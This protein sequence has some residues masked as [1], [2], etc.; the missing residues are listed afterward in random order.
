MLKNPRCLYESSIDN[1]IAIDRDTIFGK[2]CEGYHGDT[3]TTTREAWL[4]EIE[5][6]Q[7]QLLLWKDSNGQI[8]FEYDIP[9]LGKRIDVVLLLKGI[10]FCLEFKVGESKI[11]ENDIDQVLDY[12][13]DLR[14]FHKFSES[15]VI[16]PI[17][18][19]TKYQ[20]HSSIIQK[21]VYNDKVLNPLVTGEGGIQELINKV[22][23]LY[24]D[25][26]DI[27][28]NW[29]ISPYAPT[30]TII[31]AARTLY[32]SHSVENITRHEAD[33]VMTD[34]TIAYILD[35][36]KRSKEN[37]EKSICFVTGVPGAGKTLVGLDVAVKQTYRGTDAPVLDEGAIY[38]SGNG[39]LVA[40]LNEALALDNYTK[41]KAKGEK[42]NK[43]DSK[44]EVSKFIQIIHRYR[45]TMLAKIKNPVENGILEIDE[46]KAVKMQD[47]GYGEVEHVAI[48]DEAQR[49][50]THER[51][52]NYL[53]RG[54]TYGNKLKVPNFPMSEASFLI[55]SLDQRED[56]A[57]IVCLVGGGQE[58][59]TGEAGISEWIKS[60]NETFT[61]WKV[62]ISPKLTEA[63]YAEGQVNELLKHN[64]NVTYSDSLHLGVSLRSYR[65]EKLSAFVHA[66]LDINGNAA[67]IFVEIKDKYPIVLTRDMEKAKKWLQS[68]VRGTERTGVLISKES[69][70]YKPLGIHVLPSGDEDAV[71]WFLEDKQDTRSS[72]YLEDAATEIQVQGLELDYTCL[73]WDADMRYENGK[74]H[75]YRFN[76]KTAWKEITNNKETSSERIKYMLNA[77]RVLLTRARVGMVICVPEGN[78]T[79]NPNGYW[80]DSTRLPEYYDGTYE[81]LR[82]LG[83]EEI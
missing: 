29:L 16:V 65:A 37:G 1:F 11:I 2:L 54:G 50:W 52:M 20:K 46:A 64:P 17:L 83:I 60:L 31:E 57:T 55:W 82:S 24:P 9:R 70:R 68:K 25:E 62:Y 48:F 72:N 13:L 28:S 27:D 78:G 69:A 58:I 56:W 79:K 51:L 19:A 81:Y 7:N 36:I 22:I 75:F 21:S 15:K 34:T 61:H 41:C 26:E 39:P 18:I 71:H 6:L 47:A 5:I 32:E 74:W 4:N 40:V 3:L 66:L 73:L 43:S 67:S 53:K 77:Y 80:E 49:S 10:I 38:L 14:N 8:I 63:E 76:G 42:K 59:N 12:A 33:K 45:D 44:R 30:P 23:S 35:V